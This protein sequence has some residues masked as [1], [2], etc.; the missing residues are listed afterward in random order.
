M[1]RNLTLTHFKETKE[2]VI[3]VF[4]RLKLNNEQNKNRL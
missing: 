2:A 3:N 4:E 1:E